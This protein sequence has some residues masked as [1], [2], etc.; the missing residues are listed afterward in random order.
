MSQL[1]IR[2]VLNSPMFGVWKWT[3]DDHKEPLQFQLDGA[4]SRIYVEAPFRF[5]EDEPLRDLQLVMNLKFE[6]NFDGAPRDYITALQSQG[7]KATKF[8][9]RIYD[10]FVETLSRLEGV[11]R[12]SGKVRH[13]TSFGTPSIHSFYS[14]GWREE[15]TW[16]VDDQ[17]PQVFRPSLKMPRGRNPLFKHPQL[18]TTDKWKRMQRDINAN[19]LPSAD[20]LELHRL[21]GRISPKEKRIPIV[22][23]AIL[24]ES[25]L[26]AYA[27]AIL[28][29]KGFTKSKIKDLRDELTF[30][31]VL[32]LVLPLTLSK[33]DLKRVS[34][35]RPHIDRIRKLRNGIVHNDLSDEA[36]SEKEVLNGVNAA[37]D[38]FEF[39][40]NKLNE[41]KSKSNNR[42]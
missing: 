37:V 17:D 21:A 41:D 15:V 36:I 29:E 6:L 16:Q 22:E 31:S 23:A 10:Y 24:I 4:T 8:A 3:E 32:N 7:A 19:R 27:E 9:N 13:L 26:K 38:L 40:E 18:V 2:K 11:L 28:P 33:T 14:S 5:P 42:A 34:K 12:V 35:W 30:N 20:I 39:I 25:K 1:I